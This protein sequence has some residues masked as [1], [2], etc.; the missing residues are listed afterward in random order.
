MLKLCSVTGLLFAL[1]A[2]GKGDDLPQGATEQDRDGDGLTNA[3]EAQWGSD[4]D[5]PDTDRDTYDDGVEVAQFTDP[6][7]GYDHPYTGGWRIDACRNDLG[8]GQSYAPGSI[9]PSWSLMD[10]NGDGVRIHDFCDQVVVLASSTEWCVPCTQKAPFLAQMHD[11][12]SHAGLM[13]VT[14]LG[15]NTENIT[16][17]LDELKEWSAEFGANHPILQDVGFTVSLGFVASPT[18]ALPSTQIID[19]GGVVHSVALE[20]ITEDMI[21]DLLGN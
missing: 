15:E 11:R 12:Y 14:L 4:P 16:P 17:S 19:R 6:I 20:D 10:Q 1:T 8:E 7:N 9:V 21:L 3:D 13:V 2:C 5:D 18:M